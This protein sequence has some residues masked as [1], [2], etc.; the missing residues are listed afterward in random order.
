M[1][2][3]YLKLAWRNLNKNKVFSFINILGLSIGLTCCMLISLYIYNELSYD[4]YHKH[5]DRLYQLGTEFI[6][7]GETQRGANTSAP[8][9][10][11]MQQQFPEIQGHARLLSLFL[12]DKTLLE[13]KEEGSAKKLFYETRGFVADPDFFKILTYNFIEGDPASALAAPNTV[14]LSEEIAAKLFGNTPAF[15][16]VIRIS[17]S[18]NGD[19]DFRITGVFRPAATPSHIDAKFFMS[20]G[21]GNMNRMANENPSMLNNNMFFTYLLLKENTD[22][23]KLESRFPAFINKYLAEDLK[24]RGKERKFFLTRVDDI[25][26]RSDIT[27]N[28]TPAVST[29]SLYILGSIAVLTLLIACINFMNL[30]TSGSSRRASEVGIRKVL[31]AQKR[32]LLKQFLG[33]SLLMA[34]IALCFAV[35]LTVFLLPLFEK[36]SGKIILVS[37][38]QHSGLFAAFILLAF[39]TGLL[40]GSYPAFYLSSFQ[41]VKVLKGRFTN[42]LSAISLRKGMVVFQFMISIVLIVSS[43]VIAGQM[44]YTRS[45]D[46]GFIKDQQVIIPLR[47]PA[48]KRIYPAFKTDISG[49]PGVS[50]VGGSMYYPGMFNPTD[51]LLYGQNQTKSES[52]TVYINFI[53]NHFLQT[54]D[55]KP[56]AGRLFYTDFPSD[57]SMQF[58]INEEATRKLGFATPGDAIGKWVAFEPD[59]TQYRLPV[60]GV[61]KDFHF[62]DLHVAIEPFGFLLGRENFNYIIAHA[63]GTNLATTIL[64]L[65]KSWKRLNPGEPFEYSFLDQDF[66]KNYQAE[67][68]Q[69]SLINYFTIIAILISCLGLFGLATFSAE[70]RTK[71]IGIRKVLGASVSG[72]VALLSRDFLK[73]VLIAILIAS[74]LAWYV[75]D[76]WLRN[77]TYRITISWKVFL[78]TTV[79]AIMI[80]MITISF[81][82]IKA[83]L[84]NPVRNLRTE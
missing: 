47:S 55:I 69:A 46:L 13:T 1:F 49:L 4:T 2:K 83:S 45:K 32:S 59:Q 37:L 61:V 36:L 22:L 20:F 15:N 81:Q 11:T 54:L 62:K 23:K 52:K 21:G 56:V 27:K 66:Q 76:K 29:T 31:G 70:Q 79:I 65:E 80:A 72:L 6:S 33:E 17:S 18:T 12:D 60:V 10:E 43:L 26:L 57:T 19:H 51:W 16:K 71:E 48:A 35:V 77:F 40:A 53:D 75:M 24:G 14:V 41:P 73:L 30:S 3:N 44:N 58:I 82:A 67:E 78:F 63:T 74:P 50:S 68:R 84:A 42:S 28:V 38:Q 64:S 34:G 25:H 9:G 7:S 8:L 39:F 5:R